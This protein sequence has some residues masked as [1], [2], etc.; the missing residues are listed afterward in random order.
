VLVVHGLYRH[1]RNPMYLS[2]TAIV[3]GEAVLSG[4]AGLLVYWAVWFAAANLFVVFYEEPNLR[5]RF[6]VEYDRYTKA[7]GRW[8]PRVRAYVPR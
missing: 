8:L 7:V 5:R 4:S 2:V 1:V 3:L 6:G